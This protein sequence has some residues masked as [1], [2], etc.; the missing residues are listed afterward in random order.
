MRILLFICIML[1]PQLCNA[2]SVKWGD[3]EFMGEGTNFYRVFC[4]FH[5][6]YAIYPTI[7]TQYDGSGCYSVSVA[8]E[9]YDSSQNWF[10]AKEGDLIEDATMRFRND[11]EYLLR[12]EMGDGPDINSGSF[13]IEAGSCVC[14]F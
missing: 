2:T 9:F 5:G 14:M 7:K 10:L 11:S 12:H 3:I 4:E 6:A 1:L 8:C 13:N